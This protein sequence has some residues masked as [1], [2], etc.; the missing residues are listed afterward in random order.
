MQQTC[1]RLLLLLLYVSS[2]WSYISAVSYLLIIYI[3]FEV[4]LFINYSNVM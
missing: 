1:M 2:Y 4:Y 3:K